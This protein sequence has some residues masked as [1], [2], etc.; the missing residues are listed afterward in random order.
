MA[1][2]DS[3]ELH[4]S[5][6]GSDDDEG[7]A[8]AP[9][10]TVSAAA[11]RARPGDVVT[12]HEG[13][14]RERVNPPRGGTANDPIVYRA[15]ADERVVL[16]GSEVVEGWE[17]VGD[18]VYRV[19]LPPDFFGGY[20]PYDDLIRGDWF[21]DLGRDHHTGAVY[22]DGEPLAEAAN[23][24]AVFD[25]GRHAWY[26]AVE[27]GTTTLWARFGDADPAG[28]IVEVN[29]R[30]CVFYP[31]EPGRDYVTVQGF[32]MRHAATQWAPPT[33]EQVGLLGTHWSK[34][35]VIEDN[36]VSHSRCSG[37]TLGK[38]GPSVDD[39][40]ATAE[41]YNETIREAR[42]HG[43]ERGSVGSHVV[44]N[45]IVCDCGQAGIVGS[46]G[47]AFSEIADN[48]IHDINTERAFSG[49]EI[50]GIKFHGPID[51][52][53]RDNRIRRARR[54][55][56]LDW[57][58]QG[59]RLTR[60]LLYDNTTDDLFV[61]VNHGPFVVDNNLL[62]SDT[63]LR[64]MSQGGAYLHNLVAGAV[65]H[66]SELDRETPFHEPHSTAVVGLHETEGGDDRFYNNVFAGHT[67]LRPYDPVERPVWMGGNIF[68]GGADPSTHEGCPRSGPDPDL[69]LTED[70]DRVT[71]DVTVGEAWAGAK[72]DL[73][74]TESL[75]TA[76][77]PG[78]PFTEPDG[79]DLRIA[80]DYAGEKRDR[81]NPLPGPFARL[82][83]GHHE[84]A[85]WPR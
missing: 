41:R 4:V 6:D 46:M 25:A 68:L 61:E 74:T 47:A 55:V 71:L 77:V 54:G 48:H 81:E 79:S 31:S 9:L 83:P 85:V 14:Y 35:W 30:P 51:A 56:W 44:R 57:M 64:D 27:D 39:T 24:D 33:T 32:T 75:G 16:K 15:P 10:A 19:D 29:V 78:V 50:A 5:T 28:G 72:T 8:N 23:R 12:V 66:Q 21:D 60:N 62:L 2:T 26:G 17:R 42:E 70:G 3:R 73:V 80:A 43:W 13:T 38:Y 34:G 84:L 37:I 82:D 36:V 11:V 7:T 69:A 22:L 67:G 65:V 18:G 59:T 63:A 52:T 76:A 53:I 45:N 58:T 20:N 40:G 49:A 1:T